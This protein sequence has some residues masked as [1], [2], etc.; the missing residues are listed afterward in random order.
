M[1]E[2]AMGFDMIVTQN[3]LNLIEGKPAFYFWKPENN[4]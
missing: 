1:V 2:V 3:T 4:E